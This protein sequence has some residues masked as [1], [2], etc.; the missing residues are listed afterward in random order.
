MLNGILDAQ[1][2]AATVLSMSEQSTRDAALKELN[3]FLGEWTL[4]AS[5]SNPGSTGRCVFEWTLGGQFLVQRTEVAG[6]PVST[7]II[8]L[9]RG[10]ETFT[11]HYFDSRGIARLYKMTVINGVWT[12]LRDSPDSSPLDFS[13]RFTGAFSADGDTIKGRWEKREGSNWEH[14]FN[15]SY[16]KVR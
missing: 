7:A 4:E 16:R 13:Q 14:D 11:Q 3:V 15:L 6:A 5:F 9:D 1:H 8:G 12:L 2:D 10:G